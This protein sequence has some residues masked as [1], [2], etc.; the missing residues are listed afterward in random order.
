MGKVLDEEDERELRK[1]TEMVEKMA[2]KPR[3]VL[4]EITARD[5]IAL[6]AHIDSLG[7]KA[8]IGDPDNDYEYSKE[9]LTSG[10]AKTHWNCGGFSSRQ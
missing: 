9:D 7:V 5:A 6:L 10:L 3:P 1:L 2:S 4:G 8:G